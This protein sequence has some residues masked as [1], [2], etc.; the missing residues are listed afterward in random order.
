MKATTDADKG[1]FGLSTITAEHPNMVVEM[2][3]V[4][5]RLR[6]RLAEG[7]QV[8]L[9]RSRGREGGRQLAR[10][11]SATRRRARTRRPRAS[12]S[13]TARSTFLRDGPWVWGAVEKAPADVQ[14]E[15]EDRGPAVPGDAGR[16]V[17]TACTSRRRPMRRRRKPRGTSSQMAAS[18]E[19]QREYALTGSPAP[20]K[21][22]LTAADF[23]A[24]PQLKVINDEAGEGAATCSPRCRRCA[25]TTTT[26]RRR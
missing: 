25:R 11:R 18:P 10:S 5:D 20:R 14:A 7:R 9:H 6:R 19:W 21:G 1:Q 4:G 22:A 13:S 23:A 8:Q 24:K 12:S 26:S 16:R 15:P 3:S 2:A 17:A